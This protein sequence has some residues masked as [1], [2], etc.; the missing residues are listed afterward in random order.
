M[1]QS[2]P[3]IKQMRN[4]GLWPSP[5]A[6]D[7]ACSD[8]KG[9]IVGWSM[10]LGSIHCGGSCLFSPCLIETDGQHDL[11]VAATNPNCP[12]VLERFG[13]RIVEQVD[14]RP[15]RFIMNSFQVAQFHAFET[16]Q[17]ATLAIFEC[18][19]I[20]ARIA[21]RLDAGPA[22]ILFSRRRSCAGGPP[23]AAH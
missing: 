7:I 19:E 12:A 4:S 17:T 21:W 10:A 15:Q 20:L 6:A 13:S 3:S 18:I 5:F 9:F 8:I 23:N 11:A 14:R 22:A 1:E 2:R 16:P